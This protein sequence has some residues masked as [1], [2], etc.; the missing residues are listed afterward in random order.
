[1]GDK[2]EAFLTAL[3][4]A[5][6]GEDSS[7][8]AKELGERAAKL[9]DELSSRPLPQNT[10]Y[11]HMF[12]I[13]SPSTEEYGERVSDFIDYTT[14]DFRNSYRK[15]YGAMQS[16]AES[17]KVFLEKNWAKVKDWSRLSVSIVDNTGDRTEY[18]NY[19]EEDR[20]RRED[21]DPF[22]MHDY[23]LEKH[24]PVV[25]L[26]EMVL[27]PSDGDFSVCING[28]WHNWIDNDAVIMLADYVEA[29]LA[30]TEVE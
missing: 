21:N 23:Y 3:R 4:D 9:M 1:M 29:E 12:R 14:F 19:T 28:H 13:S 10:I 6:A 16:I 22:D 25:T 18:F 2:L 27:D 26:S 7:Q 24:N 11:G 15:H 17:A 8:E 5:G 30:T 20:A